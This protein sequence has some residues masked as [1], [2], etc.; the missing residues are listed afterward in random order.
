MTTT[1][2]LPGVSSDVSEF[3]QKPIGSRAN[4]EYLADMPGSAAAATF[5]PFF[6]TCLRA[7]RGDVNDVI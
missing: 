7:G 4:M 6:I 3:A 2:A 1:A 5:K